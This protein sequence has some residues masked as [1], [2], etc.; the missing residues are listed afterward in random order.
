[1]ILFLVSNDEGCVES[2]VVWLKG[3]PVGKILCCKRCHFE[4]DGRSFS[5]LSRAMSFTPSVFYLKNQ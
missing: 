3:T 5:R 1:M 4:E 2:N